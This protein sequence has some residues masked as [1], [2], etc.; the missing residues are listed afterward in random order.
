MNSKIDVILDEKNIVNT[1]CNPVFGHATALLGPIDLI[2]V[3]L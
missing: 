2:I 3:R 1:V